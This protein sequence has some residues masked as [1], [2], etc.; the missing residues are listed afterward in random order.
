M[1]LILRLPGKRFAGT[2]VA[3]QVRLADLAPTLRRMA[4][5]PAAESDGED[6]EPLF[7][8]PRAPDRPAFSQADY[9]TFVLG[10]SPMR[11]LRMDGRK[12][13]DAP[14]RELY[15]LRADAAETRNRYA[16][17]DPDARRLAREMLGITARKPLARAVS[18]ADDPEV[19]RRLASLGYISG[20]AQAVDYDRIDAS[21]VDPKDHIGIWEK[22][23]AGLL[24]RQTQDFERVVAIF[25]RLF[26]SYPT[27]NPV[28][29]RDYAQACRETGRLDRAIALYEKVLKT[30]TPDANDF[31]GLGVAWHRKGDEVKAAASLR[32][33]V[34]LDATD[35]VAWID[36][37][38]CL[39]NTRNLVEAREAFRKAAAL[40]PKAVDALSGLAS[41]AFESR[42]FG[43]SEG[44]LRTA[45]QIAPGDA[46]LRFH[47]ALVQRAM[48]EPAAARAIYE[49]LAKSPKPEVSERAAR[50]LRALP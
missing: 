18:S 27:I 44:L 34:A 28:I 10:W 36:L 26:A 43:Q 39:L 31:F 16:D 38:S 6:L 22:I 50:E 4:A 5:L 7:A 33:A 46:E 42:D 3:T 12:F 29:L 9:A 2:R 13:I 41:I 19:A 11:A 35:K 40:D 21:R 1:P 49:A 32:Q 15:D 20:G 24:A 23:E 14:R 8:N 45:L 25:E 48:G 30:A 17:Q 47:L 37:G